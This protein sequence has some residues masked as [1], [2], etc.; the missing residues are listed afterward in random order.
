M[1]QGPITQGTI[2]DRTSAEGTPADGTERP[3]PAVRGLFRRQVAGDD[4]LLALAGLRFAQAGMPAE[5]YA[6]SPDDLA[7]QLPFVPEHETLP[8]VHLDRRLDLLE[9]DGRAVVQAFLRRF[10]GRI[11]GLVVHDRPSMRDRIPDLV[12][13]LHEVGG[14]DDGPRVFLEYAIGQPLDWFAEVAARTA[15][16]GRAGVC[17]DTGHVGLAEVH[18]A[19]AADPTVTGPLTVRDGRLEAV[20]DQVQTATELALPAVLGLL[21]DVAAAGATVHFHLHDGHPAVPDLS[22]HF[23]FLFRLPVPFRYRGAQSLA[24]MYGPNGLAAILA[25]AVA[26]LPPDRLSLTLEIHQS[27]GRQPLGGQARSLFRG[28][29]DLTNAE[30]L[31]YWLSVIADNHVLATGALATIGHQRLPT[32]A[33]AATVPG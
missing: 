26:A 23:G 27:E 14:R 15:D 20:V 7:G 21:G 25:A 19:L 24:P 13:A 6:G 9:P 29:S 33:A 28:W 4:A 22:D 12:S 30:R 1:T 17:I 11:H 5:L 10:S 32:V 2:T 16:A 3:L 8:T 18:R 31:N